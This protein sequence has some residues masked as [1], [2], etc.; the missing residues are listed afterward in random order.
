MKILF[1]C[2]RFPYPVIGGD[3]VQSFNYLKGLA[4]NHDVSLYVIT[5]SKDRP[6]LESLKKEIPNLSKI[7]VKQINKKDILIN[8]IKG[9][10]KLDPLQKYYYYNKGISKEFK[11][12]SSSFDMVFFI[13]FR[14]AIY[15]DSSQAKK[16]VICFPDSFSLRYKRSVGHQK[17][18]KN[19][20]YRYESIKLYKYERQIINSFDSSI[21]INAEDRDFIHNTNSKTFIIKNGV[22]IEPIKNITVSR[23]SR[24]IV[25]LGKMDYYP[26]EITAIHIIENIFPSIKKKFPD[27][28]LY[29]IGANPTKKLSKYSNIDDVII[30][31]KVSRVHDY[32]DNSSISLAPMVIASGLQNKILEVGVLGIPVIT[33]YLG[34]S[35]LD[36]EI[37]KDIIVANSNEEIISEIVKLFTD[38]NYYDYISSNIRDSVS[39]KYSWETILDQLN[40]ALINI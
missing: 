19:L 13:P 16:N 9:L 4:E 35:G 38:K 17:G 31:G 25:F 21:F 32:L 30:T 5:E 3:K 20:I 7:I 2:A 6:D 22:N 8:F 34:Y 36:L 39:E 15:K 29:I 11:N 12:Y 27:T 37:G 23:E 14:L 26:N 33:N 10:L 28:K 40:E 1:F 24:K 18:I